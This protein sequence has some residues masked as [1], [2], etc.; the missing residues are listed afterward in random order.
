MYSRTGRRDDDVREL[1]DSEAL[2]PQGQDLVG[3][4]A[5]DPSVMAT[6][7]MTEASDHHPR[8]VRMDLNLLALT[9]AMAMAIAS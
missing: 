2:L 1:L 9:E 7:T 6:T 5:V 8:M 3:H 4:V